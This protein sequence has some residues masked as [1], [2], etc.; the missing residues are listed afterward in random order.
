MLHKLIDMNL[1]FDGAS[2]PQQIPLVLKSLLSPP[3]LT[4][5]SLEVQGVCLV[6]FLNFLAI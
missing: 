3:S 5:L 1:M 2:M 4:C 6:N